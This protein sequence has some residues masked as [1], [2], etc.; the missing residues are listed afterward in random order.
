MKVVAS[1]KCP[2]ISAF[3]LF[4]ISMT[5]TLRQ[6]NES[7]A[8]HALSIRQNSRGHNGVLQQSRSP[9]SPPISAET[10]G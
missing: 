5:V 1:G 2:R 10:V 3:W 9:V 6:Y 7:R 8:I 4:G